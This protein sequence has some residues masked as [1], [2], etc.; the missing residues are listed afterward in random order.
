MNKLLKPQKRLARQ[1]EQV[2]YEFFYRFLF[3]RRLAFTGPLAARIS[4]CERQRGKRDV[5]L[6]KEVWDS[7]Y[8]VSK[9]A[10]LAHMDQLARYSTIV[11]YLS[12]LKLERR[13]PW[14]VGCGEGLLFQRYQPYGYARYVGLDISEAALAKLVL[15]QDGKTTFLRADAETYMP[16]EC[17]TRSF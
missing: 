7:Q 12:Q 16:T 15:A 17:L 5:I 2:L 13:V 10:F 11:G 1:F 14:Y 8:Q 4:A 3:G 9:W 6:S